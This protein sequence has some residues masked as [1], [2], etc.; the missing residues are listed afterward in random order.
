M[1]QQEAALLANM[2]RADISK[3]ENGKRT[4]SVDRLL[5][6]CGALNVRAAEVISEIEQQ[7]PGRRATSLRLPQKR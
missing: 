1:S 5:R 2:D 7:L 6:I 4:L 3:V